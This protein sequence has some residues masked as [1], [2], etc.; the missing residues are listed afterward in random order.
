[1]ALTDSPTTMKLGL[2]NSLP[3]RLWISCFVTLA[4]GDNAVGVLLDCSTVLVWLSACQW[5]RYVKLRVAHAPGMSGTCSPPPRVS[6]PDMHHDT[7]ITHVP[8]CKPG[9]LTSG[10]LWSRWWGKRSRH[11][12]PMHNPQFYVF[13]KRPVAFDWLC[14]CLCHWL[15]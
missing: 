7:C 5:G 6:D 2:H 4:W 9:S 10:F 1:M 12:R 11:S 8:W 13:G 15:V 14:N 3:S